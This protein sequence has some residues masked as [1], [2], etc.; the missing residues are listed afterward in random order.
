MNEQQRNSLLAEA[1]HKAL[2]ASDGAE[3]DKLKEKLADACIQH[4][5]IA[6][7]KT[8]NAFIQLLKSHREH[9]KKQV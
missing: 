1:A 7:Q 9:P 2:E 5:D 3:I 8:S 4:N 6:E